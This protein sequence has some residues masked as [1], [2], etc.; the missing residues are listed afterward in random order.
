MQS[1]ASWLGNLEPP[2]H[3]WGCSRKQVLFSCK[4]SDWHRHYLYMSRGNMFNLASALQ[5][6]EYFFVFIYSWKYSNHLSKLPSSWASFPPSF[7]QNPP[8]EI[9]T[10]EAYVCCHKQMFVVQIFPQLTHY[11][12]R[13]RPWMTWKYFIQMFSFI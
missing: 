9:L 12:N 3:Q 1:L 11:P 7:D 5:H 2:H 8:R 6:F 4:I 13:W 10:S